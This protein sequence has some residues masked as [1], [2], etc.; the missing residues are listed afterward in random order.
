MRLDSS[1]DFCMG[2]LSLSLNNKRFFLQ[3]LDHWNNQVMLL[4]GSLLVVTTTRQ[5]PKGIV[6]TL[7]I[8]LK[9][10][11][12]L[13][14]DDIGVLIRHSYWGNSVCFLKPATLSRLKRR[15]NLVRIKCGF[16]NTRH[17]TQTKG[18]SLD[19]KRFYS[20]NVREDSLRTRGIPL[21]R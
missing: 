20:R 1:S 13:K 11:L 21:R 8:E 12:K 9:R 18:K 5:S 19:E 14:V 15:L 10:Q 7:S 2:I 17:L 6:S 4:T 3:E 16:K